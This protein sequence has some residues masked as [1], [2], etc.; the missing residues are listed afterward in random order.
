MYLPVHGAFTQLSA[1]QRGAFPAV[2]LT[3]LIE[4]GDVIDARRDGVDVVDH[5]DVERCYI[6]SDSSVVLSHEALRERLKIGELG[7]AIVSG[8]YLRHERRWLVPV[9]LM[10]QGLRLPASVSS[11]S[12]D[13]QAAQLVRQKVAG[14]LHGD[15]PADCEALLEELRITLRR[16]LFQVLK[17]KP[18]VIVKL[19]IV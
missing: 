4:T 19:H 12:F 16:H 14:M 6:D 15:L 17:K 3:R 8:V 7:A 11:E 13:A 18:V 5:L 2:P 10:L 9:E 1:N